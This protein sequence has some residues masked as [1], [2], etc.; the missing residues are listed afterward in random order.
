[1][2]L[3]FGFGHIKSN[4]FQ[5]TFSIN[6]PGC[7]ANVCLIALKISKWFSLFFL[8]V[9]PYSFE[10]YA[11]CPLCSFEEKIDKMRYEEISNNIKNK[12]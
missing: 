11:Q 8:P 9:F 3:I 7:N 1:M 6:C 2:F 12:I 5:T 4:R 10:Y